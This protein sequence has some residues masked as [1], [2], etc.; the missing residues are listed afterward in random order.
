MTSRNWPHQDQ[1][2]T[3][4]ATPTRLERAWHNGGSQRPASEVRDGRVVRPERKAGAMAGSALNPG[5][6]FTLSV[7]WRFLGL[8]D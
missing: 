1:G 8:G 6:D 3:T 4:S 2:Q 5:L 7:T